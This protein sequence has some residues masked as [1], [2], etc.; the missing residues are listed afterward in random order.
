MAKMQLESLKKLY[1]G[2]FVAMYQADYRNRES[3]GRK[4]YDMISRNLH[5]QA[6]TLGRDL[7]LN[8][9]AMLVVDPVRRR[10]LLTREFRMPINDYMVSL[11]A[12]LVEEGEDPE[13]ALRRELREEAGLTADRIH[14]LPATFS[15]IG[16]TDER[17]ATAIVTVRGAQQEQ[18][19]E[20]NEEI[21]S[22]WYSYEE[23]RRI[24]TDPQTRIGARSAFLTMLWLEHEGV[25]VL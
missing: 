21:T 3:G 10:V 6:E 5:L 23:A 13:Q 7:P 19:L 8:A 1:A 4:Q 9:I 14:L 15:S 12:G 17:V 24:V 11:P 16:L 20:E 18:H 2:P 22:A 25:S